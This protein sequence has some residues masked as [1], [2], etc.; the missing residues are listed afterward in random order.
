V[1]IFLALV[2][3]SSLML[4]AW[5]AQAVTENA[6]MGLLSRETFLLVNSVLMSV[7]TLAV[8]LGTLY[9]LIVDALQLGKLSVG[10]PYFDVVFA[11][12][13]VPVLFIM[14]PGSLARWRQAQMKD[15]LP[16]LVWPLVG[17]L[18][19]AVGLSLW[20]GRVSSG[21]L[22]GFALGGWVG[23][24]GL[25]QMFKR[26][27]MPGRIGGSFW[28][29]QLA[30][31]GLAIVVV[32]ITGVKS[33]EIEKDVRMGVGDQVTVDAYVFKLV[34]MTQ[35]QGPNYQATRAQVQVLRNGVEFKTL[36][37][38]KRRYVSSAM[39]MTEAAIDS[40]VMQDLYVSLGDAL[41]GPTPQWSMRV[42]FKPFVPWLWAGVLVMVLGGFLAALDKR[43][44]VSQSQKGV[45]A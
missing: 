32:G 29:M 18:V 3:G 5:R 2:V 17:A 35:V 43:Y 8:L 31:L 44:R 10:P 41:S 6:S 26:I 14:V 9:P 7:A 40:G 24:A 36:Y 39:P 11:P 28:G 19:F 30:H 4:F 25:I 38:E 1:L 45:V 12:L 13:M 22:L 27:H 23:S 16:Q 15:L 37:P 21:V 42:Y 33:F 20:M 34:G